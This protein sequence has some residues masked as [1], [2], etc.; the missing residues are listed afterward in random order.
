M[1]RPNE[2]S[3]PRSNL[4]AWLPETDVERRELSARAETDRQNT[5]AA[6]IVVSFFISMLSWSET[7]RTVRPCDRSVGCRESTRTWMGGFNACK[8]SVRSVFRLLSHLIIASRYRR[9]VALAFITHSDCVLHEMGEGHPERP[10]R[11]AAIEDKLIASRLDY[12]ISRYDAPLAT[13]EQLLRVHDRAYLDSLEQIAPF[14]GMVQIDPDTAMNP[15]TLRAAL[16]AAGAAVLA[17][18]LVISGAAEAAF[19]AVRPPGHHAER[20]RAMGFCFFNYVAVGAAHALASHGLARGPFAHFDVHRGNGTEDMFRDDPRVLMVSTFEHPF[21]PG[22][23]LE[24]RSE[25]MVNVPLPAGAGSREFRAA[26]EQEWLPALE[27]FQP[28]MLFVSAGFDAH[29]DDGMAFLRFVEPDYSWV[30]A[31][32]RRVAEA[33]AGGRIVSLL[34]GGYDLDVLGRC[35]A[36]HL[37]EL[38]G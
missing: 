15:H 35:V 22:S 17:T 32:L 21:Y 38:I 13:R 23:G 18:D 36:V 5:G 12:V 3:M 25:R 26:V 6:A 33:C 7:R 20:A 10:E 28:Q 4:S 19:C 29:R 2:P 34:E 24:G 30:T 9:R 8:C 11:L 1:G 14:A 37:Q 31:H 27:S 16:R